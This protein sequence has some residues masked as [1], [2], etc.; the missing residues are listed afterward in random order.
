MS[1]RRGILVSGSAIYDTLVLPAGDSNWGTTTFVDVMEPHPGG[2]GVNTS[3]ALAKLGHPVRLVAAVGDDE[4]GRFLLD[5]LRRAGVDTGFLSIH[6]A[7]ATASTVVLVNQAGDR[8]F[9]HR[10]GV[11]AAAFPEPL[12][13]T[14]ALTAG[15]AR[16]H[17]ASLFILPGMREHASETLARARAAGLATSLD[18]NWDPQGRWMEDLRRCLP[19]LDLMFLN[20]DEARMATGSATPERA[21]RRLL[22]AGARMVVIKLGPRGC[23]IFAADT[24]ILV[25][26]FT[27]D[28]KDTTGAGDCFVGGFLAALVDGASLAEAGRYAN[29]VGALSVQHL[30][31]ASGI[32]AGVDLAGWMA[33]AAGG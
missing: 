8:K 20:E 18:T 9:F 11:S 15:I 25:P 3:L 27:V 16:Y 26:G 19:H 14:P 1:S 6:P 22:D 5:A 28:V 32:P 10:M 17:L 7:A 4:P 21:A 23:G 30:G 2:N 13:F 24:D 31:G 12:D 29:A 33:S